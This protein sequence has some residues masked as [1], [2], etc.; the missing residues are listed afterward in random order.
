MCIRDSCY[1]TDCQVSVSTSYCKI[2][3]S[4][5]NGPWMS[6]SIYFK[7]ITI[8][9]SVV[10]LRKEMITSSLTNGSARVYTA[11]WVDYTCNSFFRQINF[12]HEL[13]VCVCVCVRVRFRDQSQPRVNG[14]W[15]YISA[16]NDSV[17]YEHV[18]F[19]TIHSVSDTR[20]YPTLSNYNAE[21]PSFCVFTNVFIS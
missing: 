15:N 16:E 7:I 2:H 12:A 9:G 19:H 1:P 8:L 3:N 11:G 18:T 10:S 21:C 20:C 14:A 17:M 4:I 5:L 13:T 6:G